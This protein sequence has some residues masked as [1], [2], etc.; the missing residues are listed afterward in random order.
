M[1]EIISIIYEYPNEQVLREVAEGTEEN[2]SQF[3]VP[4]I[5]V[6]E[7]LDNMYHTLIDSEL[8]SDFEDALKFPP[9][10]MIFVGSYLLSG[11]Q[12]IW[13]LPTEKSRNHSLN[14]Y[15]GKLKNVDDG[16][17][18]TRPPT[19]AEALNTQVN[20]IAGHQNRILEDI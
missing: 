13:T 4:V 9:D 6:T 16:N 11:E 18:G 17:G 10:K 5:R 15:K 8:V 1:G 7:M 14:K 20:L 19:E 12:F 3:N 2:P